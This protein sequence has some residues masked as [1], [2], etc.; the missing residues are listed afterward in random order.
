MFL[1]EVTEADQR[2]SKYKAPTWGIEGNPVSGQSQVGR[3][4]GASPST[5]CKTDLPLRL[6]LMVD[7]C[8]F[9]ELEKKKSAKTHREFIFQDLE[10]LLPAIDND[11]PHLTTTRDVIVN[12]GFLEDH[13]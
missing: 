8:Q 1:L 13:A 2:S 3:H 10:R 5:G 4:L 9:V 11:L 6:L 12:E 7:Q